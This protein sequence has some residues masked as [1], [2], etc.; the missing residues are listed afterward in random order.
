MAPPQMAPPSPWAVSTQGAPSYP[1]AWPPQSQVTNLDFA[2][3]PPSQSQKR[4]EWWFKLGHLQHREQERKR[5]GKKP[6][7]LSIIAASEINA[8]CAGKNTWDSLVR[9]YVPRILDMSVIDWDK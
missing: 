5:V 4:A 9:T 7:S 2:D 3:E 1:G 6:H 8:G